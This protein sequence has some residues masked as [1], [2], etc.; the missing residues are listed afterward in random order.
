LS[1]N[2]HNQEVNIVK[3]ILSSPDNGIELNFMP[4]VEISSLDQAAKLQQLSNQ[5]QGSS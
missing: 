3:P 2:G 4:N 1:G 5:S